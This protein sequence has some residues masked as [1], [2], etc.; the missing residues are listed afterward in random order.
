LKRE[1]PSWYL[2]EHAAR[3]ERFRQQEVRFTFGEDFSMAGEELSRLRDFV[4][5]AKQRGLSDTAITMILRHEGW[6]ER[7]IQDALVARYT[8]SFDLD[9]PKRG[10]RSESARE[11][12]LYLLSFAMLAIWSTA[13]VSLADQLIEHAFPNRLNQFGYE[14]SRQ[15]V[16]L[17]LACLIVA[18]PV[19][20]WI[21]R[22]LAGEI[23]HRPEAVDSGVRKWLTYI[24]LVV[25]AATLVGDAVGTLSTFLGGDLTARFVF[26]A[27]VLLVVAG[28]IFWYY[29]GTVRDDVLPSAG[30]RAFGIAATCGVL[31][32][33]LFGF[34]GIGSPRHQRDLSADLQRVQNLT[35]VASLIT[36]QTA[37]GTKPLPK[38]LLEIA[39]S[40]STIRDP[41]TGEFYGYTPEDDGRYRLCAV[42]ATDN[43]LEDRYDSWRHPA[44][45][46]CYELTA[47]SALPSQQ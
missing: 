33:I 10:G 35:L 37:H 39:P 2:Q 8:T 25:A 13:L 42:F 32:A 11:A 40:S 9:V 43:R 15:S 38:S 20:L 1:L 36:S 17:Q 28:G 21:Q 24:A 6:S 5:S 4:T 19:Y 47:T 3:R 31:V 27:L 41:M 16:A 46:Y 12:F 23:A 30:S 26:E 45:R 29:L 7:K 22:L 14:Y 44:G 18:Y 34:T